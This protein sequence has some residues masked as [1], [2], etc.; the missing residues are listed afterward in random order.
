MK[1]VVDDRWGKDTRHKHGGYWTTEY[2]PGM[3]AMDHPWE[4][5]RGMGYLLRLQPR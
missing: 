4:E 3:A 1:S 5:S 2:T